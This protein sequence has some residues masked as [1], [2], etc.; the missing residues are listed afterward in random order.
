MADRRRLPAMLLLVSRRP[1]LECLH[2]RVAADADLARGAEVACGRRRGRPD[3]TPTRCRSCA[4]AGVRPPPPG[5]P[6]LQRAAAIGASANR[7]GP[8]PTWRASRPAPQ[9][10]RSVRLHVDQHSLVSSFAFGFLGSH[11]TE[12]RANGSSIGESMIFF[13]RPE[14]YDGGT[15][16]AAHDF[17]RIGSTESHAGA[18]SSSN[19][20]QNEQPNQP[21]E[22]PIW[23]EGKKCEK[24][25]PTDDWGCDDKQEAADLRTLRFPR[26]WWRGRSI[27]CRHLAH[28][29][30]E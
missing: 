23:G 10:Q 9:S 14:K 1:M 16:I 2:T 11:S 24:Q 18:D 15:R 4:L 30:H 21:G 28:V 19:S 25:Y 3:R 7:I 12:A 17:L 5:E 20:H 26:R 27:V 8:R 29:R 22:L 6:W 13:E